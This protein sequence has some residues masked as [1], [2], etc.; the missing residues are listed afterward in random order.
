MNKELIKQYKAEFDHW[1]DGGTLLARRWIIDDNDGDTSYTIW[2]SIGWEGWEEDK[3]FNTSIEYDKTQFIINDEY[4]EFRK[5]LA[6]G[7]TVQYNSFMQYY[8]RWDDIKSIKPS[9]KDSVKNYRIKS[10]PRFKVGDWV[11]DLKS[12]SIAKVISNIGDTELF[13]ESKCGKTHID[14]SCNTTIR[15]LELWKPKPGEWCWF[16][17]SHPAN[18]VPVLHQFN[19]MD[20]QYHTKQ[21]GC[22]NKCEPF[23]GTLPQELQ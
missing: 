2:Y 9:K 7:K 22:F 5:A 19:H 17:K 1:L 15:D 21:D 11:R 6:E 23:I 10:E 8:N 13:I 4:V 12:N 16:W 14:S 3:I 20:Y 18:E